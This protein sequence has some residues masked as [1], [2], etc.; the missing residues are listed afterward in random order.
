MEKRRWE[1]K[2]EKSG[3]KKERGVGRDETE[4]VREGS[5]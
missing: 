2:K 5:N 1:A 4:E 3:C